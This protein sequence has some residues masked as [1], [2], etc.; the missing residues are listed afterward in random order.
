VDDLITHRFSIE[1][2]AQAYA[3][4]QSGADA[5]GIVLE[6]ET[7]PERRRT[8]PA[9]P[10]AKE[11]ALRVGL[12]GAGAFA[13]GTLLPLLASFDDVELR[14]VCA[15]TGASAKSVADRFGAGVVSTAWEEVVA[16]D[17]IDAVLVATPHAQ[18][19]Q[20]AAAALR[21]GKAT[22][23]EK[24]LAIDRTG[25]DAIRAEVDGRVLLVGHNRRFA[26][27]AVALR[28]RVRGRAIVQIR[29]AA[30]AAAP[31]HW[32]EDPEQG[33]RVL[34]EISHFV[35]LAAFL[36]GGTPAVTER[37]LV[38]GSLLGTLRFPDGSAAS[39]AYGTG[40]S[41]TLP[42]ERIEVLGPHASAVLDDFVRLQVFGAGATTIKSRRDKGHA[43][44]MRAFVDAALGRAPLPVPVDEQLAVAEAALEL[45][46]PRNF[47]T[48][49][50]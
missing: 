41:G 13:R 30:G 33:G 36:C 24:P 11:G 43:A 8:I 32:L 17:E 14:A 7:P 31:G 34:G 40:E 23:V 19:A 25:L 9:R 1:D 50:R 6:Y 45:V 46:Q 5:I 49:A 48:P 20:I 27:L 3:T 12:V 18:H 15:R 4:L 37:V 35:D 28:E 10:V 2:G 42:K 26:A 44:Q 21:A 16:L 29:V 38:E 47:V 22:F 39:V